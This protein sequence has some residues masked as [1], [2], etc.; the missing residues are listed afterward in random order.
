MLLQLLLLLSLLLG[1]DFLSTFDFFQGFLDEVYGFF[2][3]IFDLLN[4]YFIAPGISILFLL[5]GAIALRMI[6][7]IFWKGEK[8]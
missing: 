2:S 4:S 1:G 5:L 7:N 6:L 3:S 8:G